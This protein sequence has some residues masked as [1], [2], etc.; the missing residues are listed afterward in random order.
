VTGAAGTPDK[1]ELDDVAVCRVCRCTD[2]RAC[3]RGCWW[4][5]DPEGVGDICSSC[6]PGYGGTD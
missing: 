1:V 3:D 6:V 2:E 4:V 5:E